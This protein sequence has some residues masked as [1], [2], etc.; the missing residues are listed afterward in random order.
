MSDLYLSDNV[1]AVSIAILLEGLAYVS[2]VSP[3][4]RSRRMVLSSSQPS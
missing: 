3:S 4:E 2:K 1:P